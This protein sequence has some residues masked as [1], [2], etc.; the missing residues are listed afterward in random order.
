MDADI[1]SFLRYKRSLIQTIGRAARNTHSKVILYADAITQSMQAAI[2]ETHR[3]RALQQQY[4]EQHGISPRSVQRE[5]KKSISPLQEA[6]AKASKA[7]KK[8]EAQPL[9]EDMI[10]RMLGLEEQMK[11]AAEVFDFVLAIK[12]RE[13]WLKLKKG[14]IKN[15]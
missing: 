8:K 15:K 5:V 11:A 7:S 2:G 1:E 6:I 10:T 12:L 13:E 4:N 9:P 14:Q 3:R